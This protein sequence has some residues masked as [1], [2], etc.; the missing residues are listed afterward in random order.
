MGLRSG[1]IGKVFD[2]SQATGLDHEDP[3]ERLAASL[4]LLVD[5]D[6]RRRHRREWQLTIVQTGDQPSTS[7]GSVIK[8]RLATIHA[9]VGSLQLGPFLE[10][11]VARQQSSISSPPGCAEEA[12]GRQVQDQETRSESPRGAY[13]LAA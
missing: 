4:D 12:R 5:R 1:A 8:G 10:P 13:R 9:P 6:P 3:I 2:A 11:A 7:I